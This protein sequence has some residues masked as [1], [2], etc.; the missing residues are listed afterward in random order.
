MHRALKSVN[1]VAVN[2]RGYLDVLV[3]LGIDMPNRV[4][5]RNCRDTHIVSKAVGEIYLKNQIQPIFFHEHS[6]GINLLG[7][8]WRFEQCC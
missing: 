7:G 6:A 5:F 8:Y 4:V 3:V 1:G 2:L